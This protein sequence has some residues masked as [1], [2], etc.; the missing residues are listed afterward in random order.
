MPL[1]Q[2]LPALLLSAWQ[3][4]TVY[5]VLPESCRHS[6]SNNDVGN[7]H[8]DM[9]FN[10]K[11]K[12]L[13]VACLECGSQRECERNPSTFDCFNPE[14]SGNLVVR[15][16]SVEIE[17]YSDDYQLCD[18][19]PGSPTCSYSCFHRR[20]AAPSPAPGV[21][22]EKVC[23]GDKS[24]CDMA[25][26]PGWLRT[27]WWD[28]YNYNTAALLGQTGKGEWY[29]L[30]ADTKGTYWRNATIVKTS[31]AAC[32]A[33]HFDSF[34]E[35]QGATCFS[36]CPQPTNQ[37]SACWVKCFFDTVLGPHADKTLKKPGNQT[38]A[39]DID[40]MA[41]AWLSAFSSDEPSAGGCPPC[42]ATG[43]CPYKSSRTSLPSSSLSAITSP[44]LT[45]PRAY[46]S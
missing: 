30:S 36:T 34:V 44:R 43:P 15:Q 3:T 22:R 17:S 33:E 21:G 13:P 28:Y 29:S 23:G 14:S 31:N 39:L 12:Y 32:Q 16:I 19:W 40:K 35:Q 38:G 45:S 26:T 41:S 1:H 2:L 5:D 4:V 18:V 9:Y 6:V 20:V 24:K 7:P 37:S 27:K 11:D 25:P 10:V 8:G 42:P 46:R